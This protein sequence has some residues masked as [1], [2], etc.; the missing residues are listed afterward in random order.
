MAHNDAEIRYDP[1]KRKEDQ[2]VIYGPDQKIIQVKSPDEAP[3]TNLLGDADEQEDEVE[4]V[5]PQSHEERLAAIRRK[6]EARKV[7]ILTNIQLPVWM[8]GLARI[9]KFELVYAKYSMDNMTT[10][11]GLKDKICTWLTRDQEVIL[12]QGSVSANTLDEAF[13]AWGIASM[14]KLRDME[15]QQKIIYS[16]V[17]R[18]I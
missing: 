1:P 11:E 14:Q 2:V 5:A 7:S 18:V 12:S 10:V 15:A 8:T 17:N 9:N 6:N 3:A 16:E 4:D 13:E